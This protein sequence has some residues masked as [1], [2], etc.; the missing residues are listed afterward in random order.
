MGVRAQQPI[1]DLFTALPNR[2]HLPWTRNQEVGALI[3]QALAVAL[4]GMGIG[5]AGPAPVDA[6]PALS[7]AAMRSI[8]PSDAAVLKIDGR[9]LDEIPIVQAWVAFFELLRDRE[10]FCAKRNGETQGWR[11]YDE[12]AYPTYN[13]AGYAEPRDLKAPR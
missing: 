7:A 13:D 12:R 1:A 11:T 8:A 6:A 3:K 10:Y 5:L 4:F 9:C 2:L